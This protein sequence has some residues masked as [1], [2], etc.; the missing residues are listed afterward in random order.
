MK[1]TI[2]Q[3]SKSFICL[4]PVS[5]DKAKSG[6]NTRN[7]GGVLSGLFGS[8]G[9]NKATFGGTKLYS[10]PDNLYGNAMEKPK[11]LVEFIIDRRVLSLRKLYSARRAMSL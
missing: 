7:R 6:N 8:G 4:T 9:N 2:L 5:V 3:I 10:L 11:E 1:Y